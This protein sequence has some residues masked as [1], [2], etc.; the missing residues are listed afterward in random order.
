MSKIRIS[1]GPYRGREKT[2]SD[3][4][5][6]IGRDAEAGIQ[7]LDRAASRFHAEVFPVGGMWF[8][9]DLESKNGTY[10]ND[11]RLKDEELLREGDVIKI[12]STELVYE[13]GSALGDDESNR[14][15]YQDDGD[16]L[17]RTL[18]FRLDEL[19]DIDEIKEEP[20][21]QDN[22][23]GLR[24]LYQLGRIVA[25]DAEAQDREAKVLDYLVQGMPTE[26]ALIFRRDGV[27]GKLV[28]TV[29]RTV[30]P[31]IQP[32]ISRSIIKKVFTENKALHSAN[33]QDDMR[34]ERNQ[35]IFQKDIRSVLCVPL[36]VGGAAPRGV[37]YLSRGAGQAP[38]DQM[39]LELASAVAIQLGLAQAAADQ[40]K[41]QRTTTRQLLSALIGALEQQRVGLAGAGDRCARTCVALASALQLAS[42][43]R[44]TLRLAG[45][46]HHL[47]R[48]IGGDASAHDRVWASLAGIDEI[49]PVLALVKQA[50]ERLDSTGPLKQGDDDLDIEPRILAVAVAFEERTA[51]D[52]DA[53]Q[54]QVIDAMAREAG[55]DRSV[56]T[57]LQNCHLNGSLYAQE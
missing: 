13:S 31:H 33:A 40:V 22:A 45:L 41:R 36:S 25:E 51:A 30:A 8:V 52:F 14:V 55:F 46:I 24:L 53:D 18:E 2:I 38:F 16:S 7:I 17:G 42:A 37:L 47:D 9:R 6:S 23:R 29:V 15:S 32:V 44:E 1:T 43:G 5:L 10:V 19:S 20:R 26:S 48:L 49:A 27:S 39:D 4:A 54:A 28:P 57:A 12:G 35:S 50:H 21:A 56:V 34:F 3:K 11:E